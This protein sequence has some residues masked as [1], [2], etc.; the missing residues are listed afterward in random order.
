MKNLTKQ[1]VVAMIIASVFSS[2]RT[3]AEDILKKYDTYS[4]AGTD[5]NKAG[6]SVQM[7]PTGDVQI[8]CTSQLLNANENNMQIL[9]ERWFV[10]DAEK[11]DMKLSKQNILL[12]DSLLI[13]ASEYL[14]MN[15]SVGHI[16]GYVCASLIT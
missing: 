5:A 10:A 1:V 13:K 12:A 2:C 14:D 4:E 9:L 8:I 7:Q 3:T 11:P 16:S 6:V 15:V